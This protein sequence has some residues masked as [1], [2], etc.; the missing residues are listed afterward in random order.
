MINLKQVEIKT[1]SSFL[2][3]YTF[4]DANLLHKCIEECKDKLED[5]ITRKVSFFSDVITE[6]YMY[7]KVRIC[8]SQK[9]TPSLSKILDVIN[10]KFDSDYNGIIINYYKDGSH[11]I[12][13]HSDSQNHPPNGVLLISYGGL[14]NFRVFD[15]ITDS[16]V[17]DIPL[18][19]GEMVHMGGEFQ[20]EFTHDVE[21]DETITTERYSIS[22][23]KYMGLGLYE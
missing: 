10:V 4:E 12:E 2:N 1:L 7:G 23:H 17:K 5:V 14:R 16:K 11:Y 8:K 9:L 6:D 13:K 18:V 20:S 3:I 15:K 21:Q 19:M 22:F